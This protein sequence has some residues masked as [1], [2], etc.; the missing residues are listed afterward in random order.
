M[1]E[2]YI[3]RLHDR[4]GWAAGPWDKEPD[5]VVWKDKLTGMPCMIVRNGL[6]A[7]CGYVGVAEGHPY[8]GKHYDAVDVDVHGGLTYA[9]K[10][11]G[12]ICHVPAAGEPDHVWWFGFDCAHAWDLC[13]GME[14]RSRALGFP[15][16]RD[17][18]YRDI[19]YVKRQCRKL[20]QQLK[21]AAL[22]QEKVA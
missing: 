12:T 8:F 16:K 21:T 17:D 11:A 9:H 1:S 19:P 22:E 5:K 15:P 10:C 7:L 18:V 4:T 6:G 13:P 2:N 14:A 20:A 3:E